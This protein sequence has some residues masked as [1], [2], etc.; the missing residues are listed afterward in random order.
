MKGNGTSKYR[1]EELEKRTKLNGERLYAIMTNHLPHMTQEIT[2]LKSRVNV[3]VALIGGSIILQV[4][5]KLF[6]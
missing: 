6:L 3:L 5:I 2:A 1:I 4:V